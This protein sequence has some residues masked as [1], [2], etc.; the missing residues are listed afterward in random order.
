MMAPCSRTGM[1]SQHGVLRVRG[2]RVQVFLVAFLS[3]PGKA[4]LAGACAS[5]RRLFSWRGWGVRWHACI[6]F[7][8]FPGACTW[9][10]VIHGQP[11]TGPDFEG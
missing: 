7:F 3:P 1:R 4:I 11:R 5:A 8:L 10:S 6:L 2:A 9:V